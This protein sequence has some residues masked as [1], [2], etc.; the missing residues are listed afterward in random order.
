MGKDKRFAVINL[1]FKMPCAVFPE[2][3]QLLS[4]IYAN[5][6]VHRHKPRIIATRCPG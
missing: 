2:K 3:A 5:D 4:G 6:I 1:I